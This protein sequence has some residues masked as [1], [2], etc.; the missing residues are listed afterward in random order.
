MP[1]S[2]IQGR[3]RRFLSTCQN[4]DFLFF[5]SD[6]VTVMQSFEKYVKDNALKTCCTI[7]YLG[8]Y[9]KFQSPF[10]RVSPVKSNILCLGSIYCRPWVKV[11]RL[12]GKE[13]FRV[14]RQ[15]SGSVCYEYYQ[16]QLQRLFTAGVCDSGKFEA[17]ELVWVS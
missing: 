17:S 12:L 7:F 11:K 10:F 8:S 5:S 15:D 2:Q 3:I 13:L 1:Y 9:S 16:Q 14:H 6:G 4:T